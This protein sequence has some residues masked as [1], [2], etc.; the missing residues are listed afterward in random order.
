MSP[1][2]VNSARRKRVGGQRVP[3]SQEDD[4][5]K[6]AS[7]SEPTDL[8]VDEPA[9]AM[10]GIATAKAALRAAGRP[11]TAQT[12][13][14][15]SQPAAVA[16]VAPLRQD[17]VRPVHLFPYNKVNNIFKPWRGPPREISWI[18][19]GKS[20]SEAGSKLVDLMC[21]TSTPWRS[22]CLPS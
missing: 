7:G 20:E 5:A 11:A 22:V 21:A 12:P 19:L 17:P 6:S 1:A 9:P 15:A 16:S 4:D 3:S 2:R 13:R 10:A 18:C 8:E 14:T